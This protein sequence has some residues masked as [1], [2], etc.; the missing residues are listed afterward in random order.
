M[1]FFKKINK[2]SIIVLAIIFTIGL[3]GIIV[4][5]TVY[6]NPVTVTLGTTIDGFAVLSGSGVVDS[7]PSDVTGDVGASPITGAAIGIPAG[8]EVTGII[9]S[10]DGAGTGDV[11]NPGLLTTAKSELSTAYNDAN[12]AVNATIPTELG[13]TTLGKGVY[14]SAAGDF[15]IS[16]AIGSLTLDGGNNPNSIFIF[17]T[18]STFKTIGAGS[19]VNLIN[20]AQACNVFWLVGSD[21]TLGTTSTF[22]GTIMAVTSI[23]D[24][25]GSTVAGRLLADANNDDAGAV[26]LDNTTVTVPTCASPNLTLIKTR[27][28]DSGGTAAAVDWTLTA[29]GTDTISG[30]TGSVA[31]TDAVVTAGVYTLS[32]SVLPAGY[33]AGTYSCVKNGAVAVISNTITLAGSD[34]A[35]CTINNDDDAL[36][37]T[38]TLNV[39]KTLTN[40]SG[41]TLNEEDFSFSVNGGASTAFEADG[42][43]VLTVAAG[44]YSVT[45]T[46]VVGYATSYTTCTDLVIAGGGSLTCT[47]TNNDIAPTLVVNKVI[48]NDDS[49][50]KLLPTDFSLKLDGNAVTHGAVNTTTI[51]LHTVSE[52]ADSGYTTTIGGNCAADGKITLAL[53]D[54]KTCTITNDDVHPSSG[55]GGSRS[56]VPPLLDVVKIPSPLALPLG[57]GPVT[58]TYTLRNI[59]TVPVT[60]ITMVDDTCSPLIFLSGDLNTDTKLDLNEKWTYDCFKTLSA[61]H[62]NIIT[63]TG[64]ANGIS[65]TDIASATVVVGAS[66][67]PPLIHVTKVPSPLAL[68]GAGRVTYTYTVTNPGTEPL[69]NVSIV[70][71]KCTEL[72]GRVLGHPGDLNKNNLL[73]SNESWSFTCISKLTKTTTNTATASGSANGLTAKDFAIATV[74]VSFSPGLPKTGF[75]PREENISWFNVLFSSILNLFK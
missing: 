69:S 28:N 9:Y 46:A 24:A 65:A 43:N 26:T 25:G 23:T 49:G 57:P 38:G 61:T 52:T 60:N 71:D 73:E 72:P 64:W 51:G 15:Q 67:V 59:G 13:A 74:V 4:A 58:Y 42:T 27:T 41:G 18:A 32:E 33:T 1:K 36:P 37:A 70:D 34:D 19:V 21:A 45:E 63:A 8:P 47:I 12:Q 7:T 2:V 10:V 39:V 29:T 30:A 17:K 40:D 54:I 44:T 55:G 56:R 3:T 16:S 5:W 53:G 22:K 6:T 66:I 20:G 14:N 11:M 50:T 48:I 68:I 62:T 75:A 31:V 35:T